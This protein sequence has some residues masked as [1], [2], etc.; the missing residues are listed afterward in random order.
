VQKRMRRGGIA[1]TL[2]VALAMSGCGGEGA[3]GTAGPAEEAAPKDAT[4][5]LVSA[6]TKIQ[7]QSYKNTID[8]GDAGTINGVMDPTRK[9]GEFVMKAVSDGSEITTETRIVEGVNYVK[10]SIPGADIPGMD[11]KTWRK[12]SGAGGTGTLGSFD[13][14]DTIKSLEAAAEV[15]WAGDNAVTGTIDL[16][17]AGQQLGLGAADAAKLSSST[18]PF[19][20][21]FDGE[22]RLVR[23]VLTIPSVGSGTPTKMTMA[24]SDFG[25]PVDVKAPTGAEL[26]TS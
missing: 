12:L 25:V 7:E 24:Y 14:T 17:K 10:M 5:A 22:G 15:K 9:T 8:M 26:A 13:A 1:L 2:A 3:T 19:E 11:G 20:A 16:V 21:G 4:A 6:A 23:Y 18:V